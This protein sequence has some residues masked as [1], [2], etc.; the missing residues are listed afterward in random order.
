M[1][2]VNNNSNSANERRKVKSAFLRWDVYRP[3][4]V[5]SESSKVKSAESIFSGFCGLKVTFRLRKGRWDHRMQ[6]KD[7]CHLLWNDQIISSVQEAEKQYRSHLQFFCLWREAARRVA[8]G[9]VIQSCGGQSW[10]SVWS[11]VVPKPPWLA[12]TTT[13]T[14]WT[15]ENTH[16]YSPAS[17]RH[18]SEAE[19]ISRPL[20]PPMIRYI[21][22]KA[23]ETAP[24]LTGL[25][26]I[27]IDPNR[28]TTMKPSTP[29][30][31]SIQHPEGAL[32]NTLKP[33]FTPVRSM[34]TER[35]SF[36]TGADVGSPKK[37]RFWFFLKATKLWIHQ[38]Q[39]STSGMRRQGEVRPQQR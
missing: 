31:K 14:W 27:Y 12:G 35:W 33:L 17:F 6:E 15:G 19:D 7:I 11:S 26:Y 16:F 3:T 36:G 13:M 10:L 18:F 1:S 20:S 2:Y 32:A 24:N 22:Y 23:P 38:L 39:R 28:T 4:M 8:V 21:L 9:A 30:Y 29:N 37:M 34:V 25:E 5:F